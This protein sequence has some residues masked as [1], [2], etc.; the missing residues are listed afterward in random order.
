MRCTLRRGIA[1]T[2]PSP[3]ELQL[4]AAMVRPHGH[5]SRENHYLPNPLPVRVTQASL[6]FPK[7]TVDQLAGGFHSNDG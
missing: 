5:F 4:D 1:A 6:D 7:S 3:S 2:L